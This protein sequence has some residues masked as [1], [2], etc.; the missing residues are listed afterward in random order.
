MDEK[1]L[2]QAVADSWQAYVIATALRGPDASEPPDVVYAVKN[3]FTARLRSMIGMDAEVL[4]LTRD[5]KWH[6]S[7]PNVPANRICE[8][9]G[10][11]YFDHVGSALHKIGNIFPEHDEEAMCLYRIAWAIAH[12]RNNE[13]VKVLD[14]YMEWE[15]QS[16]R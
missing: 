12:R 5:V 7:I 1:E 9:V 3:L 14:K 16:G 8:I 11:H 2:I 15:E 10:V 13:Y 6:N 4:V